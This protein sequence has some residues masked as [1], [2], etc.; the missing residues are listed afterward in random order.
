MYDINYIKEKLAIV[1]LAHSDYESLELSLAC[2]SKFTIPNNIKI[3]ILQNGFGSYDCERTLLVANRY[4]NLYPKLIEVI[5]DIKQGAPYTSLRLL[6]FSDKLSHYDFILKIDD[7]VF[8][9]SV[10]WI[11]KLIKCYIDS[12]QEFG[13]NLAYITGLVN[14]NPY[15]FK[16]IVDILN[17]KEEFKSIS[18]EHFVG[19]L[20]T[21]PY[22]PRTF[23]EK[24]EISDAGFGT[25]WKFPYLARWIH[26]KTTFFPD[27][28]L[29]KTKKLGYDILDNKKRYSIN[30]ILFKKDLWLKINDGTADDENMMHIYCCKNNK[31]IVANLSAP[32]VHLFFYTHRLENKDLLNTIKDIYQTWL[33]IPFPISICNDREIEN[34]NRLRFLESKLLNKSSCINTIVVFLKQKLNNNSILYRCLRKIYNLF[35]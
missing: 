3:F 11:D 22:N 2:H 4:A 19:T 7:D 24:G 27:I 8:P 25:I 32:F 35:K 5:T 34:E 12:K 31:T 28:Y 15:G 14:N 16:K 18:F 30:V 26:K 29:D 33:N 21:D 20:P 17:L 1:I 23:I 6:F 9:L 13:D 10:N